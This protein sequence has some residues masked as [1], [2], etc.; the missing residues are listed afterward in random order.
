MVLINP[1]S[2]ATN[3]RKKE[4]R[5]ERKNEQTKNKQTN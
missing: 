2:V 1:P 4:G 3:E 5:K